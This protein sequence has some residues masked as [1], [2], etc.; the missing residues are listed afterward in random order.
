MLYI[1][2]KNNIMNIN[3]Y[4]TS[5][6]DFIN[7]IINKYDDLPDSIFFNRGIYLFDAYTSGNYII[8][9][10]FIS[11]FNNNI[12]LRNDFINYN[13]LD[14]PIKICK[15]NILTRSIDFYKNLLK[16]Y[17]RDNNDILEIYIE[18]SFYYI[19]N[20]H[21]LEILN[22]PDYI[23]VGSG[24]SGSVFADILST[25]NKNILIIEKRNHIGGN[26]YDYI[27][28][29]T[30]IRVSKYGAH[31]FHTNSE[32]VWQYVNK[33]S[34]WIPYYHKVYG[35]IDNKLV[36]IPINIKT[37][38]ELCQQ[39]I[40]NKEEMENYLESVRDK[41]IENPKN[42]EEYC[43]Q[44][45]GNNLY[46]K[47][48]KHY[49]KKQWD[50]YPNE[51]DV[52][53]L[54]RI[55]LR[56]DDSEGYF[57][58]KYQAMPKEGYT[59]F[60]SN[61]VNKQNILVLYNTDYMEYKNSNLNKNI[62]IIFT[63]PIDHYYRDLG[64][65]KLEY[66]SINFNFTKIYNCKNFQENSVVNYPG[67]DVGFTRI[68]EYKHFYNNDSIHTIISKEFSTDIGDPYYPVP[69]DKNKKL[70]E[71]YKDMSKNETNIIFCGRLASYKYY[72]MDEAILNSINMANDYILNI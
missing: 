13:Y 5:V 66:R 43:L 41:S 1:E 50:K 54:Q 60:I 30:N 68:V 51:L 48:I 44:K 69:N 11:W 10:D 42:S 26:C 7:Y 6:Y 4:Y 39:N 46:E 67:N 21:K 35:K 27:D 55:P 63:G 15:K 20:Y 19:F 34:D 16:L 38:N 8:D 61:I 71:K 24:L 2:D 37:I 23:V 3:M 56:Y 65:D 47:L 52:S 12:E 62:K 58:D 18:K 72:N 53:V 25:T 31:I 57:H 22:N 29:E 28:E 32:I 9:N 14:Y 40:K 36:P 64:Y 17:K 45:F 70:Y 33:Y 49:T 59:N